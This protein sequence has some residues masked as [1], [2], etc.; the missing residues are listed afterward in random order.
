MIFNSFNPDWIDYLMLVAI[1]IGGVI[2]SR[3]FFRK[4][5]KINATDSRDAKR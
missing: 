4:S 1:L 5:K 2:G 3:T